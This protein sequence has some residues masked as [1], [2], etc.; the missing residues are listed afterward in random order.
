MDKQE[1]FDVIIGGSYAGLLATITLGPSLRRM[2]II[3][4]GLPYNRQTP[5][6]HYFITP[7]GIKPS[8]ILKKAK[9]QVLGYETVSFINDVALKGNKSAENFDAIH[10]CLPFTQHSDIPAQLNGSISEQGLIQ[11]DAM[12]KTKSNGLFA[13][14]DN[15]TQ[16]RSIASAV[17]TGIMAG[18]MANLEPREERFLNKL[19]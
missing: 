18:A 2:L 16:I 4:G 7:N 6:A 5:H 15:S 17:A 3:D 13:C 1:I 8:E 11:V 19:K 14:G 12:Q 10:A 9:S